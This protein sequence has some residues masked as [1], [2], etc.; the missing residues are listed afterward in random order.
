M[1]HL[2]WRRRHYA[3]DATGRAADHGTGASIAIAIRRRTYDRPPTVFDPDWQFPADQARRGANVGS[4]KY[5][6]QPSYRLLG[7]PPMSARLTSTGHGAAPHFDRRAALKLFVSG[8]ALALASCG[9]PDEQVVPYVQIPERETPGMPLRFASCIAARRL[10]PR[11]HRHLGRRSANQESTAI[12]AIQRALARPMCL[13]KRPCCRST[14]RIARRRRSA[15]AA[16]SRGA[17]SRRIAGPAATARA[18]Q[19]FGLALLTGRVTSPT[20]LAQIGALTKSLPQAKWYRYEPVEDDA[21][22]AGAVQAFG[23][24]VTAL[25]RFVDARVVLALDA[26][27][28]GFGPE[29]IR[30]G[31]DIIAARQSHS[32]ARF[33]AALCS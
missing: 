33:A 20:L 23:Q 21:V 11:R 24:P 17:R 7:V 22:R 29:Q 13:P 19:G 31:R 8:A 3:A 9:R 10:W 26:D 18:H 12:R 16:S 5:R 32:P 4:P 30:F 15:T 6:Q 2:S 27:P 28:L 25:P 1:H 14:I